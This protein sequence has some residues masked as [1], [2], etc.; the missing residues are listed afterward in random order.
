MPYPTLCAAA[1]PCA[2]GCS[3]APL[4]RMSLEQLPAARCQ[5]GRVR[6]GRPWSRTASLETSKD[7]SSPTHH[8]PRPVPT[9]GAASS[10]RHPAWST[11][12]WLQGGHRQQL[13]EVP[14]LEAE[15]AV[16]I[17]DVASQGNDIARVLQVGRQVRGQPACDPFLPVP[18]APLLASL[19]TQRPQL[20]AARRS[21][22]DSPET[23]QG[24]LGSR[25]QRWRPPASP[26]LPS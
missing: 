7:G 26:H 5:Q 13:D 2:P 15:E 19:S 25:Q 1:D 11:D 10:A 8:P 9:G 4:R 16:V 20:Q 14:T 21:V 17:G 24:G 22:A 23:S 18:S 6:S 3:S 12:T